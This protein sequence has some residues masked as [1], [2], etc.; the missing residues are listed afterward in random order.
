[1][2]GCGRWKKTRYQHCFTPSVVRRLDEQCA[3]PPS[4]IVDSIFTPPL[5]YASVTMTI[6]TD[7]TLPNN[8]TI[9]TV[10][11]E[12]VE[13]SHRTHGWI[14]AYIILSAIWAF[15]SLLLTIGS[16]VGCKGLHVIWFYMPALLSTLA[17]IVSDAV[18]SI[19]YGMDIKDTE[20]IKGLVKFIGIHD[21]VVNGRDVVDELDKQAGN[22]AEVA[23]IPSVVMVVIFSR[24]IILWIINVV[25]FFQL[26][27]A[28]WKLTKVKNHHP[29]S[30]RKD[31]TESVEAYGWSAGR[32]TKRSLK[33][34]MSRPKSSAANDEAERRR[35]EQAAEDEE[36]N[37]DFLRVLSNHNE[38][39]SSL[40]E[41]SMPPTELRSQLPWSYFNSRDE[42]AR[43]PK[44]SNHTKELMPPVP[45]PDYT[46][47]F[48]QATRPSLTN[49]NLQ[50]P[51]NRSGGSIRSSAEEGDFLNRPH[52]RK[53]SGATPVFPFAIAQESSPH[54]VAPKVPAKP[55][56]LR[57]FD[58][59]V[60]SNWS[61][62]F[63]KDSQG[64]KDP[65]PGHRGSSY[66]VIPEPDYSKPLPVPVIPSPDYSEPVGSRSNGGAILRQKALH[67]A[68][69]VITQT[70][71]NK[72][73]NSEHGYY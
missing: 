72:G 10:W 39:R 45:P 29:M 56:T 26:S 50:F 38:V 27:V 21:V 15:T 68:P 40:R 54:R 51:V 53:L 4:F 5:E 57:M 1:M 69:L 42:P 22:N 70:P 16:C 59:G 37:R 66:P 7:F 48:P 62:R 14:L 47:R 17:V 18:A 20:D 13:P 65:T 73:R 71:S 34:F 19:I 55:P 52:G 61:T 44:P 3:G 24:A 36:N 41:N 49:Q 58:D 28:M 2:E 12:V 8:Y 35:K 63:P 60:S 31:S 6:P 32:S 9:P 11:P 67:T 33:N 46:L 23:V 25:I 43:P 64:P 30:H